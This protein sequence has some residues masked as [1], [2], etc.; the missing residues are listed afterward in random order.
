M[1]LDTANISRN[2][3]FSVRASAG[4]IL[5]TDKKEKYYRGSAIVCDISEAL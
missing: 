1:K 2:N 5:I 3:V 4:I